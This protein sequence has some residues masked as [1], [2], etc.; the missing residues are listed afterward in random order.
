V[1]IKEI[2]YHKKTKR[3]MTALEIMKLEEEN[4]NS[5]ILFREGIFWKAYEK[6]AY[7][8]Y[9]EVHPYKLTCKYVQVVKQQMVSLGFPI[10]ATTTI[11]SDRNI[12]L[13][14]E[15]RLV[16]A[17]GPID[18]ADFIAWK[19]LI[20]VTESKGKQNLPFGKQNHF[21]AKAFG[22]FRDVQEEYKERYLKIADSI[23]E[24]NIESKTP[25]ECMMFLTE[26][27]QKLIKN[28]GE[29]KCG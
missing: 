22:E 12:L 18:E 3:I 26:V 14:E 5:I 15:Q 13:H 6:S 10:A 16:L 8:F 2:F 25:L 9:R 4:T 28:I 19:Q 7:A 27:K 23:R 20:P 29:G 11:I 17:A 21:L 1:R 24:F